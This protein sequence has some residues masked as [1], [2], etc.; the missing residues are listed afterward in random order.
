[1][2]SI[3]WSLLQQSAQELQWEFC[4]EQ[5]WRGARRCRIRLALSAF[6]QLTITQD[7]T[8]LL[9]LTTCSSIYFYF[10]R[11]LDMQDVV[12]LPFMEVVNLIYSMYIIRVFVE[13]ILIKPASFTMLN[14][15]RECNI[16]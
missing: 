14:M 5:D 13:N 16:S 10:R 7:G 9:C 1:M 15:Q 12:Q 2:N 3:L 6:A 4:Q 8:L 11:Q